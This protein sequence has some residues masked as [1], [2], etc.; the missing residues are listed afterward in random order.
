MNR[1]QVVFLLGLVTIAAF[2]AASNRKTTLVDGASAGLDL[3]GG[4]TDIPLHL[5]SA[6]RCTFPQ[7]A[8]GDFNGSTFS[9]KNGSGFGNETL[10]FTTIDSVAATAQMVGNAG[11][12]DLRLV[13]G[14]GT[15]TFLELSPS[16]NPIVTT[17]FTGHRRNEL[18][19]KN[20][21]IYKLPANRYIA[22]MS[23]HIGDMLGG[24]P[25]LSQNYGTCNAV[26]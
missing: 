14:R 6:F 10:V 9:R 8:S 26:S 24:P 15:L 25:V 18:K 2:V 11:T 7:D 19:T 21:P 4:G 17:I 1:K 12:A 5:V 22:V 3:A 16:G 20:Y 13:T 23:R